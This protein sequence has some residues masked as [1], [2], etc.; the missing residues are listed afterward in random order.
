MNGPSPQSLLKSMEFLAHPN[1]VSFRALPCFWGKPFIFELE[2]SASIEP[3]FPGRYFLA[4]KA[5]NMQRP[6]NLGAELRQV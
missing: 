5:E 4:R 6:R 3:E 2:A 1:S